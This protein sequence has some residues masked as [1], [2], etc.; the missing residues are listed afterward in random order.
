MQCEYGCNQEA[1]FQLKNGK[2]CC[3]E[4]NNKCPERIRKN[5]EGLKKAY[6]EGRKKLNPAFDTYRTWSK[7]LNSL[8]CD[9]IYTKCNKNEIFVENSKAS[10]K[11]IKSWLMAEKTFI[12]KCQIC[13][14]IEWLG[15]PITLELDH[16]NGIIK[17]N[18][19]ENLRF[20]CPNCHSQTHTWKKRNSKNLNKKIVTDDELIQALKTNPNIRK[21]L[22]STGLTGIGRN[23]K[24]CYELLLKMGLEY[25]EIDDKLRAHPI[26]IDI[27][28]QKLKELLPIKSIRDISIIFNCSEDTIYNFCNSHNISIPTLAERQENYKN[29]H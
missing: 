1:K 22:E 13:N 9:K 11:M 17:D 7:G 23:Y 10:Q 19:K 18:R 21:A 4:H 16:I 20:I 2:W 8:T 25:K 28:E 15:K 14:N 29:I 3:C 26:K 24:R 12:H 27:D 6:L 5:S